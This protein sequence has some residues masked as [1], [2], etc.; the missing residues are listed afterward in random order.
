MVCEIIAKKEVKYG[1]E[2]TVASVYEVNVDGVVIG[3][4]LTAR[5]EGSKVVFTYLGDGRAYTKIYKALGM[6]LE[7]AEALAKEA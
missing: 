5:V 7:I 4:I 2:P 3:N 1:L 6:P